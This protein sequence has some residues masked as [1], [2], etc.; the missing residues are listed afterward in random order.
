[1]RAIVSC[2]QAHVGPKSATKV[3]FA[4]C[5]AED[6]RR[7][8]VE[9][10]AAAA[11]VE[12]LME[13]EVTAAERALAAL[14]L[15]CTVAEGAAEV[16]AHALAVPVMVEMMGRME[17]RGRE[18]A[19]GVL[20]VIFC[21]AGVGEG[22]EAAGVAPPEEVARAVMLALQGDCSARGKRKGAQLLKAL[23]EAVG[24]DSGGRMDG[25]DLSAVGV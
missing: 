4:L 8:A 19:I 3:L 1:M 6:N 22:G 16:R 10:G 13:L 24:Y 17:G 2:M 5:L 7:V 12:S 15:M 14:E 11:V 20:A 21:G 18:H 9:A 25:C 23:Q